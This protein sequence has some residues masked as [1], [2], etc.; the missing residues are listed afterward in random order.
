M[1]ESKIVILRAR[2]FHLEFA[3][4][5]ISEVNLATS[6]RQLP[7][8]EV[9]LAEFLAN[10]RHYLIIALE[11]DKVVGSLYG[12]LLQHPYRSEPQLFL[13]SIDVRPECRNRGIGRALVDEFVM[14]A[15]MAGAFEVWV[16]TNES[17]RAA[18][19]MYAH[20]GLKR[21]NMDD[22]MLSLTL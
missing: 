6:H 11:E 7:L 8:D 2:S 18:I 19:T 20:S 13:Y 12:Y 17:N 21:S 3:R 14:E 16:L 15:K 22:V 10:A 4:Q 5:A 9:A 1:P